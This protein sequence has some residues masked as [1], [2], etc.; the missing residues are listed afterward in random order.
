MSSELFPEYIGPKI[1]WSSPGPDDAFILYCWLD[2]ALLP[3]LSGR[4]QT[5]CDVLL[6]VVDARAAAWRARVC[7][8]EGK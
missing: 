2:G 3:S 8:E 5:A 6:P 4:K 7:E 1:T